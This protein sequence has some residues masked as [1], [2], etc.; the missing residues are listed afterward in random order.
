MIPITPEEQRDGRVGMTMDKGVE[1]EH[2]H[3]RRPRSFLP[4]PRHTRSLDEHN[5]T[6]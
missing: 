2:R 4:A 1:S 6:D 3:R 5:P